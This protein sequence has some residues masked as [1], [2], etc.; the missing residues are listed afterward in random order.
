MIGELSDDTCIKPN[1]TVTGVGGS[2]MA[3]TTSRGLQHNK[4]WGNYNPGL[5][6]GREGPLSHSEQSKI[7]DVVLWNI[8]KML[9]KKVKKNYIF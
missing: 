2:T 1:T 3:P 4:P 8:S 7:N 5:A 9:E 6:Q